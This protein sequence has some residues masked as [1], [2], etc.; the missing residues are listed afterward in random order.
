[1]D[2]WQ[3][4]V[5]IGVAL[6]I[7]YA[8]LLWL[9]LVVWTYFDMKDRSHDPVARWVATG[10]VFLFNIP[11]FFLYLIFRPH[12]TLVEAYERRLESEAL[13]AE[14]AEQHRTC[15]NCRR[16]TRDDFLLCPN[17]KT[18]LQEPCV[19]CEKPLELSWLICPYCG[20]AGPR[21]SAPAAAAPAPLA[22]AVPPPMEPVPAQPPPLT[23]TAVKPAASRSRTRSAAGR[24]AADSADG[25]KATA[26]EASAS[27]TTPSSPAS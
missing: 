13:K 16:A 5:A 10:A 24:P 26:T 15:P 8:V 19:H 27:T 1:L 3:F 4:W 17:C 9:G 6:L 7:A 2:D 20:T 25:G 23:A 22:A 18:V 14:L 21:A 11:G 12:E